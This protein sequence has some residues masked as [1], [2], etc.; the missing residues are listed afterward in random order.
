MSL[1]EELKS[2]IDEVFRMFDED[3]SGAIDA[4]EL[5]SA[6]FTITGEH[7]PREETLAIMQKYDQDNNGFIDRAEFEAMVLERMKGRSFQEETARAFKLLEDKEMPGYVTK[8]S[9]RRVAQEAGEK[10]TD[11]ELA[12]MFDI[13]VTGQAAHAVD[14]ATFCAI[15]FAAENNEK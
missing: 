11:A 5:A 6:L 2:E 13:L 4:A 8:E 7:I 9:L 1:G 3:D 10:L 15:Q 12:E 14:F